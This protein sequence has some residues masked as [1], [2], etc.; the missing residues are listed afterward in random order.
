MPVVAQQLGQLEAGILECR[1]RRRPVEQCLDLAGLHRLDRRRAESERHQLD[2][3]LRVE[4][5]GAQK[6]VE[7]GDAAGR[8]AEYADGLALQVLDRLDRPIGVDRDRPVDHAVGHQHA[9]RQVVLDVGLND[10]AGIDLGELRVARDHLL[11]RLQRG[12]DR[13]QFDVVALRLPVAERPRQ[14][15]HRITDIQNRSTNRQAHFLQRL[16]GC[17]RLQDRAH[18]ERRRGQAEQSGRSP[19]LH[20]TLLCVTMP[21]P[22]ENVFSKP[23]AKR[24]G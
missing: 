8:E 17:S 16:V 12:A 9:Q 24:P 20:E 7:I 23:C 4:P 1:D 2:V 21:M 18:H 3:L 13:Q 14:G 19:Q 11:D 5:I 10:H 6:A 15:Q 22:S